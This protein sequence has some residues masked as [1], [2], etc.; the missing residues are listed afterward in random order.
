MVPVKADIRF[1][2]T[3]YD[4]IPTYGI[5]MAAGRN[6]SRTYGTDTSSFVLNEAAVKAVGWKSAQEAVGKDL[7]MAV[8]KG[9]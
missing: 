8:I 3:D 9:I 4:F 5:P 2:A 7:Y 1:V 6:F